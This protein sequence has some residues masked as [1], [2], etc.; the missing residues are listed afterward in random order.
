MSNVHQHR[1]DEKLRFIIK[2]VHLT[3]K[4]MANLKNLMAGYVRNQDRIRR[5]SLKL[6]FHLKSFGD[7][8]ATHLNKALSMV[9]DKLREREKVRESMT[10]RHTN[11]CQ[12]PLGIYSG[13]LKN[14]EQAMEKEQKKQLQLDRTLIRDSANRTRVNQTQLELTSA[15]QEL[16]HATALLVESVEQFEAQKRVDLGNC[17]EEFLWSE[18]MFHA[19]ALELLSSAHQQLPKTDLKADLKEINERINLAASRPGSPTGKPPSQ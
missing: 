10:A 18:M 8:E 17:L 16:T 19:K 6:A 15:N 13:E 5:K 7:C 11:A 12:E 3:E 1:Q 2:D 9:A 14:R 4:N